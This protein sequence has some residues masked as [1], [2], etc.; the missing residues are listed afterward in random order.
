MDLEIFGHCI[1]LKNFCRSNTEKTK[2]KN[3]ELLFVLPQYEPV[4]FNFN[5]K[6]SLFRE[7]DTFSI[8]GI[9]GIYIFIQHDRRGELK[10]FIEILNIKTEYLQKKLN[11]LIRKKIN[12]SQDDEY[13]NSLIVS[14]LD[15]S[16]QDFYCD[17][18]LLTGLELFIENEDQIFNTLLISDSGQ[19]ENLVKKTKKIKKFLIL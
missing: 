4:I 5:V 6:G 15:N 12:L 9:I 11:T 14:F 13:I 10:S 3:L 1:K 2:I 18:D 19:R 16:L 7:N 8:N 17:P